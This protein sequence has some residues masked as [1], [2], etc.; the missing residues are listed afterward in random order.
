MPVEARTA[1]TPV[2]RE[3]CFYFDRFVR[4]LWEPL[5]RE[6]EDL[7][8]RVALVA[9]GGYGEGYL[10][11]GSDVD[12]LFLH[13]GLPEKDLSLF[14]ERLI[15]P[16]WD[17]RFE[18]TYRIFTP[19]E[20]LHFALED[21][22][23]LTA[24]FFARLVYGAEPLFRE[25]TE[26]FRRLV[27]GRAKEIYLRLRKFREARLKRLGEEIYFLEP[28]L[29]DGPGGIRDYQFLIWVGK[30]VFGVED[31]SDMVRTGLF[32]PEEARRIS[33]AISFVR[34]VRE[35]LHHLCQRKEDR[36]FME[37]QPEL[38]RCLGYTPDRTGTENFISDLFRAFAVIK[39][40]VEDLIDAVEDLFF[41]ENSRKIRFEAPVPSPAFLK[42]IFESQARR[43][44]SFD[45]HLKKYLRGRSF[46]EEEISEL[47]KAFPL[48]L[49]EPFSLTMLRNLRS[50]GILYYLIPEFR[51][52]HGKVQYDLYHLYALDEHLFLTVDALHSLKEERPELWEKVA[53]RGRELYLA[54]LLHDI[55]KGKPDH[56]AV[57]AR[58]SLNIIERFGLDKKSGEE[59]SF[60]I[61]NHL[62]LIDTA[63]R[64]D[65]A[66]ERVSEEIA[67][68][69]RTPERLA[70]L[71]LL[72]LA[73]ARAT[74][75]KALT[76]WKAE[77]LEELYQKVR[78][79]LESRETTNLA[80]KKETL[81][82][83]TPGD[84]AWS[85]P[86]H[87]LEIYELPILVRLCELVIRFLQENS[88]FV[89][90]ELV[91]QDGRS[92][93]VVC[94]DR[95]GLLADLC[96]SLLAADFR[97]RRVRAFTWP[98]GVAVDEFRLEPLLPEADLKTWRSLLSEIFQG[99]VNLSDLMA[100][101]SGTF[102]HL[103]P[104]IKWKN[105]VEIKLDQKTSDFYT[106]LE[107]Y[108]PEDPFLLY[109]IAT[110]ITQ[111][112]F[113]IGK[114]LISEK[115]DMSAQILY[116]QTREGEKLSA[117]EAEELCQK[118]QKKLKEVAS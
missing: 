41:P 21:P 99:R 98:Q 25:L 69:V 85:V 2:E 84:I 88:D 9:L 80:V 68:K 32:T 65:L 72:T 87:Q 108:T 52:I 76:S 33:E 110:I 45:R 17:Y 42:R 12:L 77:L 48:L 40:G 61:G 27:A 38:A 103:G 46:R 91:L 34:R 59:V 73:D 90:E 118:I 24:L 23:F 115:E 117:G 94:R 18:V 114:A 93:F 36:L 109:K 66:E 19:E 11:A 54:A 95:P 107:I 39:E 112:G 7:R 60:L 6:R 43:G 16:L 83:K 10:C 44:L 81:L 14:V 78:K 96:G 86:L 15:Y 56:A 51:R 28:H 31:L 55:A 29:K 30:I 100:R 63:L 101:K 22:T 3:R 106:L 92:L 116:L 8:E 71:Y 97:I 64:R 49:A 50:T 35:N 75:P 58:E 105:G 5:F 79:L 62:L 47:R 82:R 20:A 74:G 113:V 1:E 102:L 37:Y 57:G 13:T 67:L 111:S 4:R 70:A 104:K 26:G 53:A 89:A